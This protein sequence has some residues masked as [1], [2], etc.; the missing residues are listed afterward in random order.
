MDG[1]EKRGM[2]KAEILELMRLKDWSKTDL[3]HALHMSENGIYKWLGGD[4]A[5]DGPAS[6]LMHGWLDE[7]RATNGNGRKKLTRQGA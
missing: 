5:P 4:G 6:V 3:A 7:A 1:K 2:T